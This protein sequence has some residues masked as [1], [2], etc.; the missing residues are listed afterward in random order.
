M[1]PWLDRSGE[2]FHCPHP[3]LRFRFARDTEHRAS[4]LVHSGAFGDQAVPAHQPVDELAHLRVALESTRAAE[5]RIK[6]HDLST[7]TDGLVI[8]ETRALGDDVATVHADPQAGG[9]TGVAGDPIVQLPVAH[10]ARVAQGDPLTVRRVTPISLRW[11]RAS[12]RI[13]KDTRTIHT[14]AD[15][16]AFESAPA[17]VGDSVRMAALDDFAQ[18][19]CK[20]LIVVGTVDARDVQVFGTVWPPFAVDGEPVRVLDVEACVGAIGIH[21][22]QHRQ[23]ILTRGTDDLAIEV[24]VAQLQRAMVERELARVISHNAARIDNDAL[25][26]CPAPLFAP[27]RRVITNGVNLGE[28][29]LAPTIDPCVPRSWINAHLN[30]L[31][32]CGFGVDWF[33]GQADAVLHRVRDRAMASSAAPAP[34]WRGPRIYPSIHAILELS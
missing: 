6:H 1:P 13:P 19:V 21:T 20:K 11:Q 32:Q 17:V 27:E 30:M 2:A 12:G 16:R 10:A 33:G 31:R 18:D 28:I 7:F 4:G 24:P 25:N 9:P 8:T 5:L 22:R 34:V 26:P 23:T 14:V 3:N 15:A 29:G